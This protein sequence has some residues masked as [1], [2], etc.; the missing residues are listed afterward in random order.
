MLYSLILKDGSRMLVRRPWWFYF[1]ERWN[2]YNFDLLAIDG[3]T[4]KVKRISVPVDSIS[5]L[6]EEPDTSR[7]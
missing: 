1:F 3:A 7:I 6:I 4:L 2:C 5:Y